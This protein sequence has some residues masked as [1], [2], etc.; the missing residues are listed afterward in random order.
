M[1]VTYHVSYFN[2]GSQGGD[3]AVFFAGFSVSLNDS[4]VWTKTFSESQFGNNVQHVFAVAGPEDPLFKKHEINTT[5]LASCIA[6]LAAQTSGASSLTVFAHSSGAFVAYA[7]LGSF[8]DIA[9]KDLVRSSTYYC[10]D[11]GVLGFSGTIMRNLSR[12]YAVNARDVVSGIK[13][14]NFDVM[15]NLATWDPPKTSLYTC[16]V[17]TICLNFNCVHDS[18]VNRF[19]FNATTFDLHMDYN[20]DMSLKSIQTDFF[21]KEN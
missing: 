14:R 19:P 2:T 11:G 7:A 4:Q 15:T 21:Q 9:S 1:P 8:F 17:R 13:S 12:V 5:L 3:I 18:V 16:H 20:V 6:H 10:L